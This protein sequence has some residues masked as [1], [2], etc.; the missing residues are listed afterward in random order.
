MNRVRW[1]SILGGL[2]VPAA[3]YFLAYRFFEDPGQAAVVFLGLWMLCWWISEA[4]PLFVTSLL[5]LVVL[6]GLGAASFLGVA[7]SYVTDVFFLF[8]GGFLLAAAA[9]KWKAHEYFARAALQRAGTRA[10]RVI[11]L[12]MLISAFLSMWISN[13]A[14]ALLMMPLVRLYS[15]G[16][17]DAFRKA[18]LL[19]VGYAASIGGI[20]TLI[21]SPPNAMFAAYARSMG[22]GVSFFEWMVKSLPFAVIGIVL[23]WLYLTRLHFSEVWKQHIARKQQTASEWNMGALKKVGALFALLIVGL[24]LF[25]LLRVS[26]PDGFWVFFVALLLFV[27]PQGKARL[28]GPREAVRVPWDILMLFGGGI[29]L[30]VALSDSG[31]TRLMVQELHALASVHP[32]LPWKLIRGSLLRGIHAQIFG[33]GEKQYEKKIGNEP[34]SIK[35]Q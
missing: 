9:E 26:I 8:L 13:S 28:L 27:L 23:C 21:G 19:G 10:S 16:E 30:S 20:A 31:V 24:L 11:L 32:S 25:P 5:P 2:C 1:V 3:A 29:A 6:P 4:V 34:K 15:T 17:S 14:T 35:H 12:F 18:M 22:S 7:Q 33:T